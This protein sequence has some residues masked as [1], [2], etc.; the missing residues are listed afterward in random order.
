MSKIGVHM[1]LGYALTEDLVYDRHDGHVLTSNFR[2][3]KLLTPLDMPP[4]ETFFADT[5]EPTGAFGA[6]GIDEGATNPIAATVCNAIYSGVGVRIFTMPPTLGKILNGL[7][8][9]Q[10]K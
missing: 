3:C 2:D 4:V 1:G 8:R 9:K 5:S 10:I 7:K 6:K